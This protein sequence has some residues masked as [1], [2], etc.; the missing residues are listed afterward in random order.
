MKS[1]NMRNM[2][3]K[4]LKAIGKKIKIRTVRSK[5]IHPKK[6]KIT[7]TV[8]PIK[9]DTR[10]PTVHGQVFKKYKNGKLQKQV[11]VSDNKLKEII[12]KESIKFTRKYLGVG[13]A[14]AEAAAPANPPEVRVASSTS[15][16]QSMKEGFGLG[17][18]IT[19]AQ[20][21]VLSIFEAIFS[22]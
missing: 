18:G 9:A 7:Y 13:G 10:D 2:R 1:R 4:S 12:K 19:A 15:F 3:K 6:N 14:A 17:V 5:I 11:F 8:E 21:F 20:V 16:F 22:E